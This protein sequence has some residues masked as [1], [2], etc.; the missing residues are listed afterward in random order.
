[1]FENT[2]VTRLGMPAEL[3][4]QPL[5]NEKQAMKIL[6]LVYRRLKKQH[7]ELLQHHHFPKSLRVEFGKRQNGWAWCCYPWTA[8]GNGR[9]R[10]ILNGGA[11]NIGILLHEF[12]HVFDSNTRHG[13]PFQKWLVRITDAYMNK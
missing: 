11:R 6:R 13:K 12:A 4:K 3:F 1:M 7:P 2:D 10:I 5:E 8:R 9:Y